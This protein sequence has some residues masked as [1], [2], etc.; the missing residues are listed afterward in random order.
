MYFGAQDN[1]IETDAL[2][3]TKL[4]FITAVILTLIHNRKLERSLDLNTLK[5]YM[6]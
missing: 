3:Y 6:Y 4:I 2:K 5:M 1:E